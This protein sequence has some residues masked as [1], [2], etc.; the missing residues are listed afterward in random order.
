[1]PMMRCGCRVT[2]AILVM[3][4]LLVLLAIIASGRT[5]Y[6][7]ACTLSSSLGVQAFLNDSSPGLCES[8]QSRVQQVLVPGLLANAQCSLVR[9]AK[10]RDSPC[11][12]EEKL[13]S[14]R[15]HPH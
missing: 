11:L 3:E 14:W 10:K 4:M 9:Q 2:A 8:S 15:S 7:K 13:P 5:I 6:A 12:E 1:M